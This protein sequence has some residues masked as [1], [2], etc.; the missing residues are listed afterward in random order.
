MDSPHSNSRLLH[1]MAMSRPPLKRRSYFWFAVLVFVACAA[2]ASCSNKLDPTDPGEAYLLF[3]KAVMD[4]DVDGMWARAA[5]STRTYFEDRY[6]QLV[7]MDKKIE[8]Y[9]PRTDHKI[10]RKQ[11]GTVLVDKVD[12]GRGLFEKVVKPEQMAISEA[13]RLGSLIEKIRLSKDEREAQVVTRS[14]RKYRLAK[15]TDGEWYVRVVDSL[16]AVDE[17]FKWLDR[18]RSALTETV[19]DL[20]EEEQEKREEIIADLMNVEQ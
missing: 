1:G 3:R 10:A 15:G 7:A 16:E 17:S 13:R 9:L 8:N 2:S 12:G 6:E 14:G 18:N 20:L 19:N 11:T 4:G 5:P